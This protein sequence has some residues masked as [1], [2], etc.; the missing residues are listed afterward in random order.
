L[1]KIEL[2]PAERL[3]GGMGVRAGWVD[4]GRHKAR[5]KSLDSSVCRL[6]SSRPAGKECALRYSSGRMSLN[7]C[8]GSVELLMTSAV[9]DKRL[10][11]KEI[12]RIRAVLDKRAQGDKS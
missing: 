11:D 1:K 8:K 10:S 12:S 6:V 7:G 4:L 9:S 5:L 3:Q 2:K